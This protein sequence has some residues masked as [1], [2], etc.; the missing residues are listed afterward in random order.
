[1]GVAAFSSCSDR[2]GCYLYRF[3]AATCPQGKPETSQAVSWRM[4][5]IAAVWSAVMSQ[6]IEGKHRARSLPEFCREETWKINLFED[7]GRCE[8]PER[9]N[10]RLENK[11]EIGK[12]K[13]MR[14]DS[15][16]AEDPV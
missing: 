11:Q 8:D 15:A 5:N 1:M 13:F 14:T 2:D 16:E 10:S 7:A 3:F 4:M 12:N 9:R 6:Y